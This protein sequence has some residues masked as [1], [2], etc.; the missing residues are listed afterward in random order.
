M[1]KTQ[2]LLGAQ[3]P[4]RLVGRIE[5]RRAERLAPVGV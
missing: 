3:A 2:R 1:A 5:A 4:L